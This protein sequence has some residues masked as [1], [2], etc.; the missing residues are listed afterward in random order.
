MIIPKIQIVTALRFFH[1]YFIWI[2]V[3]SY[4]IAGVMPEL[5]LWIRN[6]GFGRATTQQ[7][8]LAISLPMLM[9]AVLLFNAGLGVKIRAVQR[10]LLKVIENMDLRPPR[11]AA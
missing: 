8:S 9:L 10:Y 7:S 1:R 6:S 5:G 4:V 11:A 3:F 2:L